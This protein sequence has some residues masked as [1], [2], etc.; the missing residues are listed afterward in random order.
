[1]DS[2]V[3]E[4][5]SVVLQT[6]IRPR[7]GSQIQFS[8]EPQPQ[9]NDPSPACFAIM[10]FT[11]L[12]ILP[13][14]A[15]REFYVSLNGELWHKDAVTPVYLYSGPSYNTVA[16]RKSQYDITINATASST[17][18]PIINALEVY[19]TIPTTNLGTDFADGRC[20]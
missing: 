1:V 5:P 4:A 8:W 7:N 11:E 2:D 20:R 9:P 17:L 3:F 13:S 19:S 14:N 15:V 6:A 18:P 16:S 12:E 10:H